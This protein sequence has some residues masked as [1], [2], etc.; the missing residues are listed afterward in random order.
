MVAE[1]SLVTVD[2]AAIDQ[3]ASSGD[4]PARTVRRSLRELSIQLSAAQLGI[5]LAA[6]LTGYLASPA[7]AKIISPLIKPWAGTHSDGLVHLA[8]LVIATLFSMLFGELVPKNAAL[9]NPMPLVRATAG[10][11]RRWRSSL[12]EPVEEP[13]RAAHGAAGGRRLVRIITRL[14]PDPRRPTT[15]QEGAA[16]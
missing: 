2:R 13:G 16:A 7:L 8:A 1:F 9:A 12:R 10:P 11:L 3:A 15:R 5:T 4:R 6:L 14:Q